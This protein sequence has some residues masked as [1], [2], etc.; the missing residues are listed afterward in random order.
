MRLGTF[1]LGPLDMKVGDGEVA[2]VFGPNGAGK[3]TLLRT[4]VGYYRLTAGKIFVDGNDISGEPIERRGVGYVPQDL[5][6][7]DNM[8]V[9]ENIEY[10]LK[11]RRVPGPE[12]SRRVLE[13]A[14]R[15]GL[16]GVLARRVSELSGGMRQRVAIARA[17]AVRPRVLLLDEPLSNLDPS[18]AESALDLIRASASDFS[19]SVIVVS[20]SAQR[21]L[22]VAD[23]VYFMRTGTLTPLGDPGQAVSNPRLAEAASYLGYDNVLPALS[24]ALDADGPPRRS[25]MVAVRSTDV[26]IAPEGKCGGLALRGRLVQTYYGVD[27][28]LRGL[29]ELPGP[30]LLRGVVASRAAVGEEVAVCVNPVRIVPV[31]P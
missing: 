4:I 3:T 23:A 17:L 15:L 6:L 2:V 14:E 7:F 13:L 1:R 19:T 5:A 29:V 16:T 25:G 31:Y 20:Q 12:R 21:L 30:A 18:S 9:R 24:L 27:G 10:G 22:R 28:L 8:D 11:A 26:T